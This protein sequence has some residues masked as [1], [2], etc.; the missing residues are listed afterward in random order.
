MRN[1]RRGLKDGQARQMGLTAED[2][3]AVAAMIGVFT[4][5]HFLTNPAY[6]SPFPTSD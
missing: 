2:K 5:P 1:N 6:A 4:D 3:L